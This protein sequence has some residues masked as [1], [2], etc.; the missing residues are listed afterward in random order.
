MTQKSLTFK[1]RVISDD[2]QSIGE[3]KNG[4]VRTKFMREF[5][6]KG[7]DDFEIFKSKTS[8][9]C[10]KKFKRILLTFPFPCFSNA[11][12]NAK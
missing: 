12:A 1:A 4:K 6:E 11:N 2:I 3:T 7:F 5:F 10:H 9:P 8:N